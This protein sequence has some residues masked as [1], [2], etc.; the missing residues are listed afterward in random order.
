MSM[1]KESITDWSLLHETGFLVTDISP[2][3]TVKQ[4]VDMKRLADF[5]GVSQRTVRS[6]SGKGLPNRAR[7]QLQNL[8]NGEYL[9]AAWRK[10]GMR[11]R[12]D[13]VELRDGVRI[14]LDALAFWKFIV[15]GVDW[16]RVR[17][18][19]LM[20]NR[21]RAT[22]RPPLT[23]VQHGMATAQQVA[24]LVGAGQPKQLA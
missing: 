2:S 16:A 5:C 23:L 3:G 9:P 12:H 13:G 20:L 24:A 15:C 17:D 10:A 14:N 1:K 11:V 19:E 8:L 22:G 7:V 6:W 18:I 4:R 21:Q